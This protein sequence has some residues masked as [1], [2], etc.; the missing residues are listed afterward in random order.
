[1]ARP[2]IIKLIHPIE[3]KVKGLYNALKGPGP[4]R[5]RGLD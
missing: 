1:M 5:A 4:A 3:K 2:G